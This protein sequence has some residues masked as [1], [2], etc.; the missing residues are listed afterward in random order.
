MQMAQGYDSQAIGT[1][2]ESIAEGALRPLIRYLDHEK[3]DYRVLAYY[4]LQDI[5]G[6]SYG[7]YQPGHN[8]V[9]RK[10]AIRIWF[11]RLESGD[12][13]PVVN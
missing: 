9:Q 6:K 4:N 3:L 13:M 10:R 12:L 8:K 5:T 7:G 1:T 2:R 11:D